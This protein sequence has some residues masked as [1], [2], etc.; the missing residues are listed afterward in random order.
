MFTLDFIY[1]VSIWAAYG[2][3]TSISERKTIAVDKNLADQ[4]TRIAKSRGKTIYAYLNQIAELALR[5]EMMETNLSKILDDYSYLLHSVQVN[6][7]FT[8][9]KIFNFALDK[10]LAFDREE[11]FRRYQN[12]GAWFANISRMKF[13]NI[14]DMAPFLGKVCDIIFS[15]FVGVE[16]SRLTPTTSPKKYYHHIK[17]YGKSDLISKDYL[18]CLY[19]FIR[20]VFETFKFTETK[21]NLTQSEI[22][23]D[24]II[25]MDES[26]VKKIQQ[27]F[28]RRGAKKALKERSS[29]RKILAISKELQEKLIEV[30][31]NR[32][33]TLFK[34]I[35]DNILQAAIHSELY[36]AALDEILFEYENYQLLNE[37]DVVFVPAPILFASSKHAAGDPEWE[38]ESREFG[39]WAANYLKIRLKDFNLYKLL[40]LTRLTFVQNLRDDVKVEL[41]SSVNGDYD[42]EFKIF[43]TTMPVSLMVPVAA[44]FEEFC[45][46]LGFET[47]ARE[48]S[49]SICVLRLRKINSSYH[50]I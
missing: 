29:D 20:G 39:A 31:K 33:M 49:H 26:E 30:A 41:D 50:P 9:F 14:E 16:F 36:S 10:F 17:L 12:Y 4:L 27:R 34:Y 28:E 44:L 46:V 22:S 47:T 37:I 18:L 23:I 24:F 25:E 13:P 3:V 35:N 45:K 48:I 32:H 43:G 42:F 1:N 7:V 11:V 5:A 8:P 19:N 15:K 6:C 40:D 2:R 21:K 38:K